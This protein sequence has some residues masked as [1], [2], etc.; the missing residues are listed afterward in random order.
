MYEFRE[1]MLFG[2]YMGKSPAQIV[3]QIQTGYFAGRKKATRV[4]Q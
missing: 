2:K 4:T 1:S 3:L